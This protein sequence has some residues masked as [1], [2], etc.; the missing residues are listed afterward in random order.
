MKLELNINQIFTGYSV[1][2]I[3]V[4]LVILFNAFQKKTQNTPRN[5]IEK[6]LNLMKEYFKQK[7]TK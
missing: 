6:G 3:K 1:A 2:L 7:T 4:N 5:E